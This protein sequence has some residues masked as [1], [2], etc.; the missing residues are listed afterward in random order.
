MHQTLRIGLLAIV[1]GSIAAQGQRPTIETRRVH[2][3]TDRDGRS[4]SEMPRHFAST[5][6]GRFLVMDGGDPNQSPAVLDSAGRFLRTLGRLGQGPG[7]LAAASGP[8]RFGAGDTLY[9]R[10]GWQIMVF[11]PSL[12]FVRSIRA[13]NSYFDFVPVADGFLITIPKGA[14]RGKWVP[15]HT[16]GP[17]GQILRSFGIDSSRR[18]PEFRVEPSEGS[19]AWAFSPF[20]HRLDRW[21]TAGIR[22]RSIDRVPAWWREIQPG[23]GDPFTR[24]VAVTESRGVVWVLSQVPVPNI[25]EV[26]RAAGGR[27]AIQDGRRPP[28]PMDK[29]Y[30]SILE[31]YDAKSGAFLAETAVPGPGIAFTSGL[32]FVVYSVSADDLAQ[33]EIWEMKLRR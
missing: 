3:L 8:F 18:P 12:R 28:L 1:L 10:S 27:N 15:F 33:L 19:A 7:E 30:T 25:N 24:V 31:A 5:P 6:D 21:T 32:H 16:T 29:M 26:M 22:T 14:E 13:A 2:T 9:V 23:R 17:T 11:S 20:T 4:F